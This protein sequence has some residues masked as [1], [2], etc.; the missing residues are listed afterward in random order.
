MIDEIA[1]LRSDGV[2]V[3]D[4]SSGAPDQ[5]TPN[6][7]R[8]ASVQALDEGHTSYTPSAGIPE[9]REAIARKL[10]AE[11]DLAVGDADVVVTPGSK[12]ALFET[13]FAVLNPGDE[14]V[15][16]QPSW[17]SYEP[18]ITFA[19]GRINRFTLP[20]ESGFDLEGPEL[21]EV[22]SDQTRLLILTNP[23]IAGTVYSGDALRRVRNLAVEHD[24]LVVSD[25]LYEKLVYEGSHRSIGSLSGMAERT[26]TVNGF[27]KGYA[28]A[29]FR[30]GYYTASA[31]IL[32][33]ASKVQTHTVSC[34]TSFAQYGGIAAL[35]GDQTPIERIRQIYE[36]RR[37]GV[38]AELRKKGFE[39]PKPNA[40]FF[41]FIPLE[42]QDDSTVAKRIFEEQRVVLLP[43]SV[44][45]LDGYLRIAITVDTDRLREGVRR[46]ARC[47]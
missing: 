6:H 14:V 37:D 44:F 13:I 28:M 23:S 8:A 24:F 27:S 45:G 19:G 33:A 4:M 1:R 47:L 26:I 22:V 32:K 43:G 25:E 40:A 34:A 46:I 10:R 39:V 9:L 41:V 38:V 11:N 20:P 7:I 5:A 21:G 3:I 2:D 12:Q 36:T 31:P 35:T 29:G 17:V 30:L 18:I 16:P 42:G 15:L